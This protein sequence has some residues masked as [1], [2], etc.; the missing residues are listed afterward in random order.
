MRWRWRLL[1]TLALLSLLISIGGWLL[2]G[3]AANMGFAMGLR[4]YDT[5]EPVFGVYLFQGDEVDGIRGQPTDEAWYLGGGPLVSHP[6]RTMLG[7]SLMAWFPTNRDWYLVLGFPFWF[8]AM[9]SALLAWRCRRRLQRLRM[10]AG[11]CRSCGYDLRASSE[12]CPECGKA[13]TNP[14][15]NQPQ[16]IVK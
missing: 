14:T 11:L 10:P 16:L 9:V 5:F 2:S 15:I 6:Y 7:F 12:R 3:G 4:R 13:I 1:L 8:V